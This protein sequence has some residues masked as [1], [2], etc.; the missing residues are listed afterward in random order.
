MTTHG[1]SVVYGGQSTPAS[2][3]P[4]A[5]GQGAGEK[6]AMLTA[7]DTY[8]AADLRGGRHPG[9]AGRRL[10]GQRRPRLQLDGAGDRRGHPAVD[11]G[12]HPRRRSGR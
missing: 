10:R 6:W 5:A 7:Y 9:D 3:A 12:G 2:R 1:E 11:E 8:S 4:P